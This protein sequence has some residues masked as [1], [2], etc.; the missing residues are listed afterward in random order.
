MIGQ[1]EKRA[2]RRPS[3]RGFGFRTLATA[4]PASCAALRIEVVGV[5]TAR[6][7]PGI[8]TVFIVG[9]LLLS[10]RYAPI[11]GMMAAILPGALADR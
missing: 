5:N 8:T 11:R 3:V 6:F 7:R 9:P 10:A 4:L 1:D 2:F